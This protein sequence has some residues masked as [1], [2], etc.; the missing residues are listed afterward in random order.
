MQIVATAARRLCFTTPGT[1]SHVRVEGG[2]GGGSVSLAL[3][4]YPSPC[5]R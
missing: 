2:G 1:A 3:H 4:V 5:A